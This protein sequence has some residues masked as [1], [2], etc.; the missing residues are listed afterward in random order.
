MAKIALTIQSLVAGGAERVMATLANEFAKYPNVEVHL[1]LM[2]EGIV[3]YALDGK[4]LVHKPNFDYKK[5]NRLVFTTKIMLFV[6]ETLKAIKPDTVLSFSGKYN[7]FVLLSALGLGLPIFISERS[8]PGISYGKILDMINP[9]VYPFSKGVI[10]QTSK[11]KAYTLKQCSH[12]N[13]A[14]IGNPVPQIANNQ[15]QKEK[16]VLNVGRFIASK[17]QTLLLEYFAQT[18]NEEWQLLFLGDGEHLESVKARAYSLGISDRVKFL[19]NQMNVIEY[20]Q[21]AAIFAFTSNSEGFPNALAEAMSAGCAVISFDINAGPSDLIDNN[22]NGFLIPQGDSETY[23]NSL[24]ELLQSE[25]TRNRFS[26]NAI[27]K[28]KQF[29]QKAVAKKYFE[30]INTL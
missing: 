13:I 20:Y 26:R 24:K 21:K 10:A 8:R 25:E 6:R 17:N 2:A 11:A 29:D 27:E 23:V 4:V 3:F 30:F 9:K 22:I 14:V 16:I 12:K 19:G 5:Y 15:I 28:M 7:S 1:I 18:C